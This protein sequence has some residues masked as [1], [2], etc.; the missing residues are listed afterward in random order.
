V[1]VTG[2]TQI[3]LNWTDNSDNEDAFD[4]LCEAPC[5]QYQGVGY[6]D[7]TKVWSV[8]RDTTTFSVSLLKPGSHFC[9]RVRSANAIGDSPYTADECDSTVQAQAGGGATMEFVTSFGGTGS[10]PGQFDGA[11]G[12]AMDDAGNIIIADTDNDR[13]QICDD[14]G[15]CS[16]L[17]GDSGASITGD[18]SAISGFTGFN[19]P[20]GVAVDSQGHIIVADTGN[21]RIVVCVPGG[22]CNLFGSLGTSLGQF[23]GPKDVAVDSQDRII[24]A[25]TNN[26]RIQVCDSNGNCSGFGAYG[27]TVGSFISPGGV[28]TDEFGVIVV[29][30]TGN[31]R[32]QVCDEWGNCG[33]FGQLGSDPGEFNSP[34]D[35]AVNADGFYFVSDTGN[36]RVQ[37]CDG[38]GN[39]EGYLSGSEPGGIAIDNEGRVIVVNRSQDTVEVFKFVV[40]LIFRNGFEEK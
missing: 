36:G 11:D 3:D 6:V 27:S 4:I 17:T 37:I 1:T 40:D 12:V 35:V 20:E 39:C 8:G 15:V 25:D 38:T 31:H 14:N 2:S 22:A 10:E 28:G 21:H 18:L 32:I 34:S 19:A 7:S 24:V 29:A 9:F 5:W 30:D 16:E 26:H 33:A 13:V 23:D